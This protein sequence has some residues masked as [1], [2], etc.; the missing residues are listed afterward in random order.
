MNKHLLLTAS[1]VLALL[2][3]S[4]AAHA[5][6]PG[7]IANERWSCTE[8]VA[9]SGAEKP[10]TEYLLENGYLVAQPLGAPR[11]RV[12]DNTAFGLIAADYS[13]DLDIGFVDIYVATLMIDRA[14]GK[15]SATNATGGGTPEARAG[16]CRLVKTPGPSAQR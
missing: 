5:Q 4:A 10:A 8:K 7:L 12:L 1:T 14:S 9:S 16:Q 13:A 15:F 6:A 11:Y 3:G 2:L